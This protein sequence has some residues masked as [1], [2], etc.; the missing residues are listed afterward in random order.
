M[1]KQFDIAVGFVNSYKL[2]IGV[3]GLCASRNR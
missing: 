2:D 1:Y 3:N